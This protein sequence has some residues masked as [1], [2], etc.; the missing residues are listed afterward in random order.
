MLT[1]LALAV[2]RGAPPRVRGVRRRDACPDAAGERRDARRALPRRSCA[3]SP[4]G[5]WLHA[6]GR[7]AARRAHALPRARDA[8]LPRRAR[9]LRVRDAGPRQRAR[10]RCSARTTSAQR[11]LPARRRA[12][13][14]SRRSRCRSP[15]PAPTSPAMT[16]TARRSG[17]SSS[18]ATKTWISNGGIAD[19][20]T[21]FA[22]GERPEGHQRVRRRRRRD[23][24]GRRAHRRRSRRTRSR[25]L[26]VRGVHAPADSCSAHPGQGLQGRAGDARRLPLDRRRGRA[27]LRAARAR[28]GARRASRR[29]SC[30][31]RRWPSSRSCRPS[32]PTWRSASTPARCSSTARRGRR[33]SPAAAS[34]ARRRWPSCT[35]PRP[36]SGSIDDAVQLFGGLGVTAGQR[37]RAAVPRDPR[38]A[39]L[40]GRVG[41]AAADHRARGA[42]RPPRR[43]EESR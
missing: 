9:R 22:R 7:R 8:R 32:S 28:R 4:T 33:T 20:Y 17:D 26:R 38:A 27:R 25:A 23:G 30:S 2:L 43:R 19:F 13:S 5:G 12:A 39:D 16:T 18:T 1:E 29:A 21:V 41:G 24:R 37:R 34:R 35:R 14:R 42:G 31:A 36:R 15:R 3:R 6:R 40:R 11:Y 10:S